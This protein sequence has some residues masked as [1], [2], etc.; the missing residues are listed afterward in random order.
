MTTRFHTA[1]ALRCL[2]LTTAALTLQL[3]TASASVE[4]SQWAPTKRH[5]DLYTWKDASGKVFYAVMSGRQT[6]GHAPKF[7]DILKAQTTSIKTVEH[8]LQSLREGTVINW[9]DMLA[10]TVDLKTRQNFVLPEAEAYNQ[11]RNAVAK[12]HLKLTIAQ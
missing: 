7:N 5:I 11:I 12:A 3:T 10:T 9:N 2:I 1:S 4:P 6:H 8:R